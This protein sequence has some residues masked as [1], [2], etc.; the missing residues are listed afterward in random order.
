MIFKKCNEKKYFYKARYQDLKKKHV[1]KIFFEI[2]S[3][4]FI[5][6]DNAKYAIAYSA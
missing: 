2:F 5:L 3:H 1:F 4:K 6:N